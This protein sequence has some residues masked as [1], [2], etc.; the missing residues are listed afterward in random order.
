[1]SAIRIAILNEYLA[2]F[3]G[4]EMA[5]FSLARAL[6]KLGYEVDV[7]TTE[8]AP[9]T[10]EDVAAFFGSVH[11]GFSIRSVASGRDGGPTLLDVLRGY[12]VL[13]NHSAGS[14]FPNP[15]P[16][17]IY[18][19]MFPFQPRGPWTST[20][21]Y[22]LC[23]SQFTRRHT[24]RRWG[25]DLATEVLHPCV[26]VE[27]PRPAGKQPEIVAIGRFNAHGHRKN[28]DLLVAAFERFMAEAPSGWT[29]SL[30][31]KVNADRPT[32]RSLADL[33]DRCDGLP[34]RLLLDASGVEKRAALDRASVFWHATG[35]DGT[36]DP[37]R[38]EHFGI[39]V[40]EAMA[41]GAVPLCF[42]GGGPR[43]IVE[44][45]RSG[46]LY[47]D[48]RELASRTA[49]LSRDAPLRERLAAGA[50]RRARAFDRGAF[51]ARVGRIFGRIVRA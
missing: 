17:G 31:G 26:D 50:R 24:L 4:G 40:V 46:F 2:T 39:A 7:L 18:S 49:E 41:A 23:N 15:C 43:E 3:G 11:A 38:Q 47:H 42:D 6:A 20:Y 45:G 30:V 48:V 35:A 19:V 12:T 21:Q 1:M 44:P 8:R 13:V 25:A 37:A 32:L 28:Q 9:P 34:V 14:T 5:T 16:L 22:F 29:L 33:A 36:T 27:G 51:D 10:P